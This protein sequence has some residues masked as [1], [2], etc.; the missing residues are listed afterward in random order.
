V[1]SA[2][3]HSRTSREGER[4]SQHEDLVAGGRATRRGRRL[5][6][7]KLAGQRTNLQKVA[8]LAGG[9]ACTP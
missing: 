4:K 6:N 5:V 3:P 2:L 7:E 1:T 8:G 9:K